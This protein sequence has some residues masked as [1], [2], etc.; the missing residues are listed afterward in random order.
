[1]TASATGRPALLSRA[2]QRDSERSKAQLLSAAVEEFSANGFA[3][4]RVLDIAFRAGVNQQLISYYFDGKRGLYR[5]ARRQ[6]RTWLKR[7]ASEGSTFAQLIRRYVRSRADL[8]SGARLLA[9]EGLEE[10]PEPEDEG[11]LRAALQ[12]V[13]GQLQA[14]QQAGEIDARTEPAVLLLILLGAGNA[15]VVYPQI[16]RALFGEQAD[17]AELAERYSTQLATLLSAR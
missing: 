15:L 11:E 6:W 10:H 4:T 7:D 8:R 1:M 3:A 16:V 5:A 14:R 13:A 17:P 12:E 2:K 9:W